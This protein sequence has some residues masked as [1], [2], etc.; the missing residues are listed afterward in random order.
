MRHC[1]EENCDVEKK[2]SPSFFRKGEREEDG[3]A[4]KG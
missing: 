1:T 4:D 3:K 2:S